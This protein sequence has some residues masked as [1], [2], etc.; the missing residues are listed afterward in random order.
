[1]A[2]ALEG[3]QLLAALRADRCRDRRGAGLAE[4]DEQIA[5]R[6][7]RRGPAV[8]QD[9]GPHRQSLGQLA[10]LRSAARDRGDH[11]PDSLGGEFLLDI[12]D[13]VGDQADRVRDGAI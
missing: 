8:G 12:G 10:R 5:D 6:P 2:L 9:G 7:G 11:G 4:L 13:E 1:M 3:P